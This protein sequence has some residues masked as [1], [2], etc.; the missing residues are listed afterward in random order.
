MLRTEALSACSS[1]SAAK[2]LGS[3]KYRGV[4][5]SNPWPALSTKRVFLFKAVKHKEPPPPTLCNLV[6]T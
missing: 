6:G 1:F 2:G 4:H 5:F 3:H